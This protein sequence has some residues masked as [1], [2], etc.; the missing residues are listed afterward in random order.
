MDSITE[1]LALF[2]LQE[3]PIPR[4][5]YRLFDDYT[6][7]ETSL[8][9]VK[10]LDAK[11]GA[12]DHHI[13]LTNRPNRREVALDLNAHLRWS[14][15]TPSGKNNL[16][17]WSSSFLFIVCYAVY[18]EKKLRTPFDQSSLCIIDTTKL[19]AGAF[20]KDLDLIPKFC[21]AVDS[22]EVLDDLRSQFYYKVRTWAAL[23]L[24]NLLKL[25]E[26]HYFGEYLSQGALK[27]EGACTIVTMDKI[28]TRDLYT[29]CLGLEDEVSSEQAL[30]AIAVQ[31]L[32]KNFRHPEKATKTTATEVRAVAAIVSSFEPQWRRVIAAS[33]F[34]LRSRRKMDP[35]LLSA[36]RDSW[37]SKWIDTSS[38]R[39]C[40]TPCA[41]TEGELD[42]LLL[43]ENNSL[44]LDESGLPELAQL[45][46]IATAVT[47]DAT[48]K[49]M[50]V[51]PKRR[52]VC[53]ELVVVGVVE[54]RPGTGGRLITRVSS[55]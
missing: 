18:R 15:P 4:Y 38:L 55:E 14:T 12:E 28:I 24:P 19:P 3:R 53:E 22:D 50:P 26:S 54:E 35:L 36:F 40:L 47:E 34:A 33:L 30:W 45:R 17:S 21:D 43:L 11:Y 29:L 46:A 1:S 37:K 8:T 44:R 48:R 9:W 20:I 6:T 52:L 25:R 32:R 5:L 49:R 23:G 7:G 51:R 2:S 16:V 10:S 39:L 31:R 42:A 13:A 41:A 27:V